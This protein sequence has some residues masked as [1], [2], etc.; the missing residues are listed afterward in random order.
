MTKHGLHI[1]QHARVLCQCVI[2]KAIVEYRMYAVP[3][4]GPIC[5]VCLGPM[6]VVRVKGK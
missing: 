1:P 3:R 2:C 4:D 6:V 5:T